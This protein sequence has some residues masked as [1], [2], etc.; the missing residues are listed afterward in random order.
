MGKEKT[1]MGISENFSFGSPQLIVFR[2]EEIYYE[3]KRRVWDNVKL[4]SSSS[5]DF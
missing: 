5:G 4:R 2:G 3:E 1:P